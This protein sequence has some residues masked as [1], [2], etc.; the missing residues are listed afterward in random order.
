MDARTR[1][2]RGEGE[3]L[4]ATLLDVAT[5]LLAEVRDV[6]RLS[7]RA[8]TSRAGVSPTALYLHFADKDALVEAIEERCFHALAERLVTAREAHADDPW[9]GLRA[10]GGAYLAFA[11][12]QPGWYGVCFQTGTHDD[13]VGEVWDAHPTAR[14]GMDV[15]GLL[16]DQVSRC[17]GVDAEGAFGRATILW[18]ALHGR[19]LVA[20]AL[21]GFPF[22]A[23]DD[24]VAL[25]A[26]G[27]AGGDAPGAGAQAPSG[28]PASARMPG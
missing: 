14:I 17:T 6:E 24:W 26:G 27:W 3:R 23:E 28:N 12:E 1:N 19:A 25:L 22:P 9:A 7:V 10:M 11:R 4:R 15:F 20:N 16:V 21:P 18:A 5:D 13:V 2:P 8:V